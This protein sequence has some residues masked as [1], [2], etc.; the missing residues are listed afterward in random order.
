MP[1][2]RGK[3]LEAAEQVVGQDQT[4]QFVEDEDEHTGRKKKPK[5]N[6][7]LIEPVDKPVNK[8]WAEQMAFNE[9]IIKIRVHESTDKLAE[10]PV[11]VFCN[12]MP[13]RFIRGQEQAVKRKY[14]EVLA[15]AKQTTFGNQK[16]TI[17][18]GEETYVYPSHTALR[19]PFSVVEDPS[20]KG[21]DWLKSVLA[22]G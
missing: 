13:Q 16:I 20:P 11:E 5:L 4:R 10:N 9:E 3:A 22:E 1:R 14:V 21:R 19:Y 15:R 18:Q 8:E 6:A 17:G 7:T 2:L 12:G